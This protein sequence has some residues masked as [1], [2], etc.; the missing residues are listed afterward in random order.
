MAR[1]KKIQ[2]DTTAAPP[3]ADITIEEPGSVTVSSAHTDPATWPDAP[4]PTVT[5]RYRVPA[6][7]TEV[8]AKLQEVVANIT[9]SNVV[10]KIEVLPA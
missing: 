1:K 9:P 5:V 7:A 10:L 8:G 3:R 6:T 4:P 2:A